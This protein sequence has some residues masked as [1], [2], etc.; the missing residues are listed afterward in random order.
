[1]ET[2]HRGHEGTRRKVKT[3]EGQIEWKPNHRG[4]EGTRRKAKMIEGQIEMET[5]SGN[6]FLFLS[7]SPRLR[8]KNFFLI[9]VHPCSSVV[10]RLAD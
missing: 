5:K 2:N 8:G 7:A 9:R 3:T 10:R 1:M 6:Q 4:H